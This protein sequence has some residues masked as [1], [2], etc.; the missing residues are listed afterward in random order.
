MGY[1]LHD[2]IISMSPDKK[3]NYWIEN[4]E[5][6]IQTAEIMQKNAR[7]LYTVF[8]CQQAIEKIIKAFH[9][10]R[11]NK[12]A[13][14]SHNLSYLISLVSIEISEENM[15]LLAE[16]STYYIEGRYPTY[17]QKI[18]ELLNR[19]KSSGILNKSKKLFKC[20]KE[21]I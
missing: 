6:D 16:L 2:I 7:Y 11:Y 5:Y 3:I 14:R 1:K 13:P 18:S 9:I 10:K 20:I 17:K 8:M 21:K 4:A 19:E 12:E 15:D